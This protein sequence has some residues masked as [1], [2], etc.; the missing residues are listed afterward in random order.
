V[1][2]HIN[3]LSGAAVLSELVGSTPAWLLLGI[4]ASGTNE[5]DLQYTLNM[6]ESR[7]P[8]AALTD[9]LLPLDLNDS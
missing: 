2:E 8:S 3:R 9:E 7:D 1:K 6:E 4:P 5:A